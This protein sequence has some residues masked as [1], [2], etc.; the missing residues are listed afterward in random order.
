MLD[1]MREF[2]AR[3]ANRSMVAAAVLARATAIAAVG[4]V[5]RTAPIASSA[6]PVARAAVIVIG[7]VTRAV[8]IVIGAVTRVPLVAAS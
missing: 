7:P 2:G 8:V 3:A 4:S 5:A 1:E 6:R